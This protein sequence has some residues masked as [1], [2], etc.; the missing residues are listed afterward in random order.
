M[1]TTHLV[2]T[3]EDKIEMNE[4]EQSEKTLEITQKLVG[5]KRSIIELY[6]DS[7]NIARQ[8][9]TDEII[10]IMKRSTIE[11]LSDLDC[12]VLTKKKQKSK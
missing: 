12:M 1:N 8:V 3:E 5:L 6:A 7:I 2:M 10:H 11:L 9:G 4:Y